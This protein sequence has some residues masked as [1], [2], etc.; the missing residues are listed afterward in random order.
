MVKPE[1][2]NFAVKGFRMVRLSVVC[3]TRRVEP[4]FDWIK[5]S[6]I[7]Q[8]YEDFEYIL[9]DGLADQRGKKVREFFKDV[10]FRFTYLPD[11]PSRW[12]GIRTAIANS[13]NT[14]LI[15]AEGEQLVFHDDRC[16]LDQYF[17]ERHNKWAKQGLCVAGAWCLYEKPWEVGRYGFEHR[18]KLVKAAQPVM[19]EWLYGG[20]CS[21]PLKAAIEVNGNDELYD[22]GFGVE[23][24]DFG[25]R[26]GRLKYSVIYDPECLV[27]YVVSREELKK[28]KERCFSLQKKIADLI[29][30]DALTPNKPHKAVYSWE[31]EKEMSQKR[32][33]LKDGKIHNAN[34]WLIQLL[35]EQ[36]SRFWPLGNAFSLA[37]LRE[38]WQ[39][40]R[41][42]C[43]GFKKFW[44][45]LE[46]WRSPLLYDWRDG[47]KIEDMK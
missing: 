46:N 40:Y 43:D 19:P 12:S 2:S 13:H 26:I 24:C 25:I 32:L 6:L 41:G 21:V 20:N 31:E 7:Q 11:K 17:L 8:E 29:G 1:S 33:M 5:E 34:E 44:K 18:R 15:F 9:V 16:R 36:P 47:Q 23:D 27:H 10:P 38:Q 35:N 42:Q 37:D 45:I 4:R 14:A 28:D 3:C 39:N 22:G 30:I